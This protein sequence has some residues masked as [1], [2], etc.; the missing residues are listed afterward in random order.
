MS[1]GQVHGDQEASPA[2]T[3]LRAVSEQ[4]DA[5]GGRADVLAGPVTRATPA[6]H[7]RLAAT[8]TLTSE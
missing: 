5:A 4:H 2:A 1:P 8:L 3:V 6:P 7:A